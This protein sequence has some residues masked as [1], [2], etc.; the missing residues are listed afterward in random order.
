[1][2]TKRGPKTRK[3]S[4]LKPKKGKKIDASQVRGGKAGKGDSSY[5]VFK[6]NEVIVT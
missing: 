2:A 5:L 6:L 3:L 1:M 4:N